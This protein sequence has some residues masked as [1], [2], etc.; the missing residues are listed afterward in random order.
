[1]AGGL[2]STLNRL[3]SGG[4][5]F[6]S[7]KTQPTVQA[8]PWTGL[9]TP[10]ASATKVSGGKTPWQQT[11]LPGST[12]ATQSSLAG[13]N[14]TAPS[15]FT[16]P[17]ATTISALSGDNRSY[18]QGWQVNPAA[19]TAPSSPWSSSDA[20]SKDVTG[21]SSSPLA[22]WTKGQMI[23]YQ[24]PA[25]ELTGGGAVGNVANLGGEWAKIDQLNDYI[26]EAAERFNV[27][28]NLIKAIMKLES[29]GEWI[30]SHAGAIG[31]MQVVP[32]YWGHLGYDL[33]DPAENIMAGAHVIRHFLDQ[34]GGDV[35]EALRRYHGIGWDGFTTDRQY[36]D[37]IMGNLETLRANGG[38]GG[39]GYVGTGSGWNVMFGGSSYPITQEMGLNSFSRQHLSGMY[40]YAT[41][42][43]ITGHAGIDVGMS[44]GSSVYA[45]TGGK[46]IRAGGSGFYCDDSGCGPGKG[47]LKIQLDNG[48][49]LII[50][51]M[52]NITVRVGDRVNP[53]M[54][55]GASG[56]AGT[57]AHIHVEYRTRDSST[58]SG[59][60][61]VDP[62]QA[63]GGQVTATGGA[64]GHRQR[65]GMTG[66]QQTMNA[67]FGIR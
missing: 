3:A 22:R 44:Y 9:P 38:T 29:G 53:G 11:G 37:I 61:V 17:K 20:E 19:A 14:L 42:Y 24:D 18:G 21:L 58:A 23:P 5:W 40:A 45:P 34:A 13:Q 63:L 43:G 48:D 51:H 7:N 25:A 6:G 54:F 62:R 56:S 12:N 55:V 31:Y 27:D 52:S 36:A 41:S 65:Q 15:M 10:S 67:F 8:D 49:E 2:A 32:K 39:V 26:V 57:G 66:L 28:P 35:Y 1:M 64:G 59:W 50:G 16:A 4:D 30:I 60:R 47:E 33:N 46:V